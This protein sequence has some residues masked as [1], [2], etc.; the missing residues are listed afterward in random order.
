MRVRVKA[1]ETARKPDLGESACPRRT[2][3]TP[4]SRAS[5]SPRV[6]R[7]VCREWMGSPYSCKQPPPPI[8]T[9]RC[10]CSLAS[11]PSKHLVFGRLASI[12]LQTP[13]AGYPTTADV[14]WPVLEQNPRRISGQVASRPIEHPGRL[15]ARVPSRILRVRQ[16]ISVASLEA[17]RRPD[18]KARRG[19]MPSAFNRR[20][21]PRGGMHRR[22]RCHDHSLTGP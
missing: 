3:H 13:D 10:R 14:S 2:R 17:S 4:R 7:A 21:T 11:S 6:L 18:R 22:P 16:G 1:Q 9:Q 8:R 15:A 5:G 20:A 19:R 12:S